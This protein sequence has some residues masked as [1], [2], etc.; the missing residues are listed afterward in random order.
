MSNYFHYFLGRL[1]EA[2]KI[3][4]KVYSQ[5]FS[6]NNAYLKKVFGGG[7]C[8]DYRSHKDLFVNIHSNRNIK[9]FL[10]WHC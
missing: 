2:K 6:K 5:N 4:K 1:E 7:V 10:N 8:D 3:K 9:S